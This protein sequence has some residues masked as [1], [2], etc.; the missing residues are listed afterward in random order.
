MLRNL[1]S[2][3]A[4]DDVDLIDDGDSVG[5]KYQLRH[6]CSKCRLL[7]LVLVLLFLAAVIFPVVYILTKKPNTEGM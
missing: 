2:P 1:R 3:A 7:V 5:I 6:H 4:G